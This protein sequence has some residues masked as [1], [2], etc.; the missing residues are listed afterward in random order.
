MTG[1]YGITLNHCNR[2]SC[3]LL[4]DALQDKIVGLEKGWSAASQTILRLEARNDIL[5][6]D[7]H[8]RNKSWEA[9]KNL[10]SPPALEARVARL[11][12]ALEILCPCECEP[13][14]TIR[15]SRCAALSI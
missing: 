4:V 13:N 3:T 7:L 2:A 9:L 15:C 6:A 14:S 12:E 11:K 1:E 8:D 10:L 5:Y